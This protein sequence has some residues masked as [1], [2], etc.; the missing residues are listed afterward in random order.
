MKERFA[1]GT[2]SDEKLATIRWVNQALNEYVRDGYRASLR[3][4]FYYGVSRNIIR[5][6]QSEYQNLGDIVTDG[7]LHGLID[8]DHVVDRNRSVETLT[9]WESPEQ[10]IRQVRDQF[11]IDKWKDQ[12]NYVEVFVE[13]AAL[14]GILLPLCQR[15][16][17]PFLSCRGFLSSTAA[18]D[19]GKR[20]HERF[21]AGKSVH[22]L[23]L[24]DHD[25][26]GLSMSAEIS[27]RLALFA[28]APVFVHRIALNMDQVVAHSL[29]ENPVKMTDSRAP[30]YVSQFGEHCWELDGI[31][32]NALVDLVSSSIKALRDEK[33]WLA[34][35][36][37]EEELRERICIPGEDEE[38]DY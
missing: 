16:E 21:H 13:K 25:P 14:E 35:C 38:G 26:S 1:T 7:R 18:Y 37:E 30:R 17:V 12:D 8:W 19:A 31:P 36:E 33:K 23:A 15:F 9:T 3:Q 29:P 28:N 27:E 5:N 22:V 34:S 2:L 24:F 10:A 11:R 32:V 20:F 6:S 4:L